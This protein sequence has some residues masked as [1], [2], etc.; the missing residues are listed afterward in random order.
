MVRL[1]PM[2]RSIGKLEWPILYGLEYC[3]LHPNWWHLPYI[4]TVKQKSNKL[5]RNTVPK[6]NMKSCI[7]VFS[8]SRY[9]P[10]YYKKHTRLEYTAQCSKSPVHVQFERLRLF[11]NALVTQFFVQL[12]NICIDVSC[13]SIGE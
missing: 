6:N 2:P 8:I 4:L 1:G 12:K 11:A 3:I 5:N 7:H 13:P 10:K 9:R